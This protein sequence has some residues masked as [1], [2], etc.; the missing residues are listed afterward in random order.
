VWNT[1]S[2][3]VFVLNA[4][5][6]QIIE[7]RQ[8]EDP[9]TYTEFSSLVDRLQ[10]IEAEKHGTSAHPSKEEIVDYWKQE[11]LAGRSI[12]MCPHP[13]KKQTTK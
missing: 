3:S 4:D 7:Q 1:F 13:G 5:A 8:R 10:R 9:T 2:Y 6:R 11:L 12:P